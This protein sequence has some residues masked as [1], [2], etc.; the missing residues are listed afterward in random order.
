MML[1]LFRLFLVLA[2]IV[3]L[4]GI[5]IASERI[6][7]RRLAHRAMMKAIRMRMKERD[8]ILPW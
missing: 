4:E 8:R 5:A 2:V 6:T 1:M 3:T 7:C